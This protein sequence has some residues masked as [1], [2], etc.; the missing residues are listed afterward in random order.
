MVARTQH[1][2]RNPD[3]SGFLVRTVREGEGFKT[4]ELSAVLCEVRRTD[5]GP[6]TYVIELDVGAGT[7][8]IVELR[9]DDLSLRWGESTIGV[10]HRKGA[11]KMRAR[12]PRHIPIARVDN[13]HPQDAFH[14]DAVGAGYLSRV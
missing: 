8:L 9:P 10:Q 5:D 3:Q 12:A 7:P 1:D 6:D 14:D 11:P 4:P 2:R 13:N